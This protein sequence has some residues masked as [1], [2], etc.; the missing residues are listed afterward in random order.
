SYVL[1]GVPGNEAFDSTCYGAGRVWSRHHALRQVNGQR[2]RAE[3]EEHGIA[4]RPSSWRGLAEEAPAAYKDVDAV[5]AVSQAAGLRRLVS[6]L[7]PVGVVKGCPPPRP[8]RW[9]PFADA[10]ARLAGSGAA[11]R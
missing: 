6:R 10:P 9:L 5:V 8:A 2:L 7:V 1:A 3:L 11:G 4:V